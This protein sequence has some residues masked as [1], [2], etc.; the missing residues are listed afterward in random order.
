M[1][2]CWMVGYVQA[3]GGREQ[4]SIEFIELEPGSY[5]VLNRD[6]AADHLGGGGFG[7]S[8]RGVA[9]LLAGPMTRPER[10]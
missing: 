3:A 8:S 9:E 5:W 10:S 4:L 7:G 2:T 6:L 1:L